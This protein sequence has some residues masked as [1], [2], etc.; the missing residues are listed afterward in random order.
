MGVFAGAA[1]LLSGGVLALVGALLLL[2]GFVWL[3]A[4]ERQAP[5]PVP[6]PESASNAGA[7]SATG[8]VV[9]LLLIIAI[10][11]VLRLYGLDAKSLTH[12]E[13]YA[14]GIALPRGV[15]EPPPR[16]GFLE[17]VSFHWLSEAHPPGFYLAMWVWTKLFGTGLVTL[18]LTSAL[19]GIGSLYLIFRVA[20]LAYGRSAGLIA[21]GLLALHGFHIYWSQIA[22]MYAPGCFL[23]LLATWLLLMM[24]TAERPR[25]GVEAAYVV[26]VFAGVATQYFFWLLLAGHLLVALLAQSDNPARRSRIGYV[27][28]LSLTLSLPLLIQAFIILG[29]NVSGEFLHLR[30]VIDFLAFGFLLA[31]DLYSL[32]KRVPPLWAIVPVMGLALLFVV[33]AVFVPPESSPRTGTWPSPP[34]R[35]LILAACGSCLL[36]IGLVIWLHDG[37]L[38][39]LALSGLPLLALAIG[40]VYRFIGAWLD[41]VSASISRH[42]PGFAALLS[43]IPILAVVPPLALFAMSNWIPMLASRAELIFVPYMLILVAVG[44]LRLGRH[45]VARGAAAV[46]L[47]SL[48]SVSVWH[49]RVMPNS[50]RDYRALAEKMSARMRPSDLVFAEFKDWATTPIY[51][52][53]KGVRIVARNYAEALAA[54]PKSRVWVVNFNPDRPNKEMAAALRA[55]YRKVGDVSALRAWGHLYARKSAPGGAPP[56]AR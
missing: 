22:R 31:P 36:M 16:I 20:A 25:R 42:W 51:Y 39:L 10:G 12:P 38:R 41:T 35:P 37:R 34:A 17:T 52:Y 40:P 5:G 6:R 3:A 33:R 23:G 56:T 50:A 30:F 32:P 29:R 27:Q 1:N 15:T 4:T 14:P 26:T 2:A 28:A 9:P 18:R 46:V 44:A 48:F 53:L 24:M 43:P 7:G 13:V 47:V 8:W 21:A 49:Y 54:S 55:D 45:R 11:A 19:L